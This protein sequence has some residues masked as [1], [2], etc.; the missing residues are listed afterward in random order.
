LNEHAR[1]DMADLLDDQGKF[2][3][4]QARKSGKSRLLKELSVTF[5]KTT[6][7]ATYRY[8]IHDP[9]TALDK[10]ARMQGLYVDKLQIEND[11]IDWAQVPDDVL[12]DYTDGK[13]TEADVRRA[14]VAGTRTR[15][16]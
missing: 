15:R 8:K 7:K 9:Q 3:L 10:L 16:A 14:I 4:A 13:I 6:K 5:D 2:S 1:G 11:S 12:D